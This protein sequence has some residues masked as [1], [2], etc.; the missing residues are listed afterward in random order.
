MLSRFSQIA[1]RRTLLKPMAIRPVG[2]AFFSAEVVPGFGKGKT[3]TGIVSKNY[4]KIENSTFV[5]RQDLT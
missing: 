2:Y 5:L 3:S 1:V 4:L